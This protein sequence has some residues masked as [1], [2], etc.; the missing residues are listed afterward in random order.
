MAE[1]GKCKIS[2]ENM[3]PKIQTEGIDA[4]GITLTVA[5]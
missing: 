3:I 5:K 1:K 4:L 2:I